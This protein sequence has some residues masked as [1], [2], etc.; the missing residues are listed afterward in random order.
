MKISL[1][2]VTWNSAATV[3]DTLRS[4]NAQTHPDVEHIVIDGGSSDATLAIVKAE[5]RRVTTVVSEPDHGIY[6]A[7][8]KGLALATG[9]IVGLL[10]SDDFLAAPHVLVTI[11]AA[12]ADPDVDAVYGDL[13]YVRQNASSQI[14]RY[15]RSSPFVP[16]AFARGWAPPHPALYIRREIYERFGRFDLAYSL[17]ADLELMARFIEIHR[18]RTRHVPQVFVHMRLGGATNKS[19]RNIVRGNREIRRALH[20]HG[21][22]GSLLGFAFG[23]LVSRGRQ[24]LVRPAR[25]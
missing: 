13:C 5:G 4:V 23:K 7:M 2:T 6:D 18:I 22:A 21:L 3:A 14:V 8:N 20:K 15:W 16:G 17:T 25:R 9:D 12:F 11:A 19:L 1:I 24:F 10:N